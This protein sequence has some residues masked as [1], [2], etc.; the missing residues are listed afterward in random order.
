MMYR[1]WFTTIKNTYSLIQVPTTFSRSTVDCWKNK[2]YRLYTNFQPL[3]T[4]GQDC[5]SSVDING[6]KYLFETG[7]ILID[8]I[9]P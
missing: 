7:E 4:R 9:F 3:K 8:V 5:I 1:Y 2:K 6:S